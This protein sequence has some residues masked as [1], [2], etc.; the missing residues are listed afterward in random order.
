MPRAP[1]PQ[2]VSKGWTCHCGRVACMGNHGSQQ[3]R[4]LHAHPNPPSD[5]DQALEYLRQGNQVRWVG[6]HVGCA[7]GP[8]W[9][10]AI[11]RCSP[12]ALGLRGWHGA[13]G[14]RPAD[15]HAVPP[16]G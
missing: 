14:L 3:A 9:V 1:P 15:A 12:L 8:A 2:A 6:R 16:C 5:P 4:W 13:L 10:D 7:S 11:G